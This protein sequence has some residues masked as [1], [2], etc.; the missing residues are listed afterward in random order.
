MGDGPIALVQDR[1]PAFLEP[2]S[3][4]MLREGRSARLEQ[5]VQAP[6]RHLERLGGF[7]C[8]E[9]RVRQIEVDVALGLFE[10]RDADRFLVLAGRRAAGHRQEPAEIVGDRGGLALIERV[11]LLGEPVE[12]GQ[13]S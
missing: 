9:R 11:D 3:K 12:L 1:R 8:P 7:L 10:P 5:Q 6:H 4:H 13:P 2:T